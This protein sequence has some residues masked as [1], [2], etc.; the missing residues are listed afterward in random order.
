MRPLPFLLAAGLAA[1]VVA[2]PPHEGTVSLSS[3]RATQAGQADL[4]LVEVRWRWAVLLGSPTVLYRGRWELGTH[5]LV[6]HKGQVRKLVTD[7][8]PEKVR[9]GIQLLSWSK[10]RAHVKGSE[11]TTEVRLDQ[12]GASGAGYSS[13]IPASP[14]WDDLL[15]FDAAKGCDRRRAQAV[16][17]ADHPEPFLHQLE[18]V[19]PHFDVNP[20]KAWLEQQDR[21]AKE[22][23]REAK[24]RARA[25]AREAKAREREARAL[26]AAADPL[27]ARLDASKPAA[28]A[29]PAPPA[30]ADPLAA[31]LDAGKKAST[32]RTLDPLAAALD[33]ASGSAPRAAAPRR[34]SIEEALD[35]KL[36]TDARKRALAELARGLAEA[37]GRCPAPDQI[38]YAVPDGCGCDI[39]EQY[40]GEHLANCL[41]TIWP[42]DY[43]ERKAAEKRRTRRSIRCKEDFQ[44]WLRR[45]R[46]AERMAALRSEQVACQA[47]A[48]AFHDEQA[49]NIEAGRPF[50]TRYPRP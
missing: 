40:G 26:A 37:K 11:C 29:R 16:M 48:Q 20:V 7:R 14:S 43:D 13:G 22:R 8:L 12:L 28:A 5:V 31:R 3:W 18:L 23:E 24:A 30:P 2:G 42:T 44:D 6:E 27:G 15:F 34:R 45:E 4:D 35:E 10:F 32:R 33:R 49:A 25:A 38:Q 17:G 47:A 50:E 1:A 46:V 36:E 21:E 41:L 39:P 19:E 9:R